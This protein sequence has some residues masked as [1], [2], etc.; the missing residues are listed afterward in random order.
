MT[1]RDLS[2]LDLKNSYDSSESGLDVVEDFFTPV[3][4]ASV[5]YWRLSGYFN[6]GML[7]ACARGMSSF[8]LDGGQM[9]LVCSPKLSEGDLARLQAPELTDGQRNS[10]FENC[11]AKEVQNIARL[12]DLLQRDHVEAMA[13]LLES[14]RLNIKLAIGR[15]A[16]L[17]HQKRGIVFDSVGNS[18]SFSGSINET[19]AGWTSNIEEFK[20]FRS[21]EAGEQEYFEKDEEKFLSFWKGG[22]DTGLEIV[23]LPD[24]IREGLCEQAPSD[25]SVIDLQRNRKGARGK[26]RDSESTKPLLRNYQRT[27]VDTWFSNDCLGIM[28]MAT[29]A[30]KTLIAATAIAEFIEENPHCLVVVTAPYQHIAMQWVKELAN[31]HPL[32]LW[33]ESNWKKSLRKTISE[34][35]AKLV[36]ARIVITVQNTAAT[37]DF[38]ALIEDKRLD[39]PK[40]LVGDEA[41]ALGASKMSASLSEAYNARLGLTA[42]PT[43]YFDEDGSA[44]LTEFFGGP[45]AE[46]TIEQAL[47]YV[48][49]SGRTVLA[50]YRY[51][52]I[53]FDLTDA[54]LES[55][56]RL[57]QK[58]IIAK[59]GEEADS[60]GLNLLY[61]QRAAVIKN[62]SG[63][64]TAV[65]ALLQELGEIR[66]SVVYCA[67]ES[68]LT[69]VAEVL[70]DIGVTY[71]RFS[72]QESSKPDPAFGGMSERER[73]LQDFTDGHIDVLLAMKCLDEGVNIPT[74]ETGIL[75]ASSGNPKE[76]IQRRGRLLRQSPSTGKKRAEIYDLVPL[77]PLD[78]GGSTS[79]GYG[80][81]MR[82]ELSRV[83][84]FAG[85]S[86]NASSVGFMIDK[87]ID[88]QDIDI[89]WGGE[90]ESI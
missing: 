77:P 32:A 56:A 6:S 40:L 63:K 43:R 31:F 69:D 50:P 21:W 25:I 34:L 23:D 64:T 8:L 44:R 76:F 49:E 65:K 83:K 71:R 67:N 3:L 78:H 53:F 88:E 82:R 14:G 80:G 26:P 57:T 81:I 18:L 62:A 35:R 30:G 75:V 72:G 13:W 55:Y 27:A 15:E 61:N 4:S 19:H 54:E 51:H 28:V 38:L 24:G 89:S 87:L 59:A 70:K 73:I 2:Q 33:K 22:K 45:V 36:E 68:Q 66:R 58:I 7:A 41:H 52:P 37:K 17:F 79:G 10:I 12:E 85:A 42:T 1:I 5:S 90:N 9:K 29:G 11:L 74:A 20:V 47:E 84:E 48:D 16:E 60:V 86:L 46:F 39:F